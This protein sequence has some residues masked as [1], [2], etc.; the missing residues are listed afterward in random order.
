[1][2]IRP[3]PDDPRDSLV[4]LHIDGWEPLSSAEEIGFTPGV[5]ILMVGPYDL[6]ISLG[7]A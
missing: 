1:M 7:V 2:Q 6:T 5:I 4:V 3:Q